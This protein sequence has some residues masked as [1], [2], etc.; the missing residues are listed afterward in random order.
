[1]KPDCSR[2]GAGSLP[3]VRMLAIPLV[4]VL[5]AGCGL[6]P[7]KGI[8]PRFTLPTVD[9]GIGGTPPY[10]AVGTLDMSA[11]QLSPTVKGTIVD[12]YGTPMAGVVLCAGTSG[13][14]ATPAGG[15][16]A[17]GVY[18]VS[19][20]AAAMMQGTLRL[21]PYRPQTRFEPEAYVFDGILLDRS[22]YDFVGVPDIYP[23]P[24]ERDCR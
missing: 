23:V 7:G 24:A 15:T 19:L 12:R 18:S 14:D 22:S 1:M 5:L 9:F 21:W 10:P 2:P 17:A 8:V 16:D 4:A 3:A 11:L 20:D 13:A 6:L